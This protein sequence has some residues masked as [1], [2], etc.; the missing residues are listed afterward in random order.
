MPEH[1]ASTY[2]AGSD[3]ELVCLAGQLRWHGGAV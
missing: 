3:M 1:P 2:D